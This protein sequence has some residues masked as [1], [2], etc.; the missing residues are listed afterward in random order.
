[1]GIDQAAVI[2]EEIGDN[3]PKWDILPGDNK[4]ETSSTEGPRSQNHKFFEEE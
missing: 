2:V 3:K 1:M 4:N